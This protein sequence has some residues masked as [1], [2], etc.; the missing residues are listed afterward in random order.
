[1][2]LR[3]TAALAL[4]GILMLPATASAGSA[5]CP[6]QL[7]DARRLVLVTAGGMATSAATMR[8]FRRAS[9]EAPWRPVGEAVPARIGRTG[10]A[11]AL[12]FRALRQG[13]EPIKAEGDK[14]SPAG[15]YRI[16]RSFGF[17]GS[18]R[19]DHLR[20]TPQTVC[21]DDP[22]SPAYNTIVSRR[23][24]G[25]RVHVERMRANSNYRQGLV[26]DYPTDAA[27]RA[28]SCIF[29]HVWRAPGRATNGCVALPEA[30]VKALQAFAAEGT[31][32]A[33]LPRHALPRL[34]AGCLPAVA[35]GGVS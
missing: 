29:I 14:R 4:A 32:L 10:M 7:E 9:P 5:A 31:A 12:A 8:L 15:V 27:R 19:R 26:V 18:A 13:D 20:V 11:W 34:P 35:A 6:A 23:Q 16:G 28:G 25:P 24:V 1:M 33:I 3:A 30:R 2:T 22:R 17:S 21:V